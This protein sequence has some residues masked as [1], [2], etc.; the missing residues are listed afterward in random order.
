MTFAA[1]F[2]ALLLGAAPAPAPAPGQPGPAKLM[3]LKPPPP[4]ASGASGSIDPDAAT[5]AYLAWQTPVS[6]ARSDAYFEG[7]HWLDLWS[8]LWSAA[9]FLLLLHTGAS[10]RMRAFA[11]RLRFRP[12]QVAAYWV[13]FLVAFTVLTFPLTVYRDFVREHRYGLSNLTLSAWFGELG[14]GLAVTVI[15]G[16]FAMAILYAVVRRLPRTWWLW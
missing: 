7:G 10:A 12:L 8:F 15:L 9:V 2:A 14:K 1:A 6:K 13:Q 11:E 3:E 16:G 5:R 4:A